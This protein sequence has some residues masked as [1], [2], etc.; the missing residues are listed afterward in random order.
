VL[1]ALG[2]Y[3]GATAV[4]DVDVAVVQAGGALSPWLRTAASTRSR[5]GLAAAVAN[6]TLVT[7]CGQNGSASASAEKGELCGAGCDPSVEEVARWSALGNTGA[8]RSCIDPG[9]ASA[10]GF[11]YLIGGGDGTSPVSAKIDVT[12]LGGTP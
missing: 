3:A 1:Y 12:L 8:L 9:Y 6:N 4:R 2:G 7:L 10:R 11:F 5:A